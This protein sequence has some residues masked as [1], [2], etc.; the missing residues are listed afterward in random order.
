MGDS[1][2]RASV[3]FSLEYK[4]WIDVLNPSADQMEQI[5]QAFGIHPLTSE[6]ILTKGTREKIEEYTT[7]TYLVFNE[8]QQILNSNRFQEVNVNILIFPGLIFTFHNLAINS[9]SMV[10]DFKTKVLQ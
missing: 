1:P 4:Y 5:Q 3:D 7:Y 2:S 9:L 6:D 10:R 8:R